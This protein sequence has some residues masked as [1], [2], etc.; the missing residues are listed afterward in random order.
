MVVEGPVTP[1][2][3]DRHLPQVAQ[4]DHGSCEAG[5]RP[6]AEL[7]RQRPAPEPGEG[8]LAGEG[9]V[10]HRI[11]KYLEHFDCGKLFAEPLEQV[12]FAT[13]KGGASDAVNT[14]KKHQIVLSPA[15]GIVLESWFGGL[16]RSPEPAGPPAER[17]ERR[18]RSEHQDG[19]QHYPQEGQN[20]EQGHQRSR[21]SCDGSRKGSSAVPATACRRRR[22]SHTRGRPTVR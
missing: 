2:G 20:V 22:V 9:P 14:R 11:G 3:R 10:G 19:D 17:L 12:D 6:V 5:Q 4:V 7:H 13:R 15:G 8:S 18:Q 1:V 16:A 21:P